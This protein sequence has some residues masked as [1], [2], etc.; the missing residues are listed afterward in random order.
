MTLLPLMRPVLLTRERV[1]FLR[2]QMLNM[3]SAD[4]QSATLLR[5]LDTLR[6]EWQRF[7][8]TVLCR[9]RTL[10][11]NMEPDLVGVIQNY[12]GVEVERL[13]T[14][15]N[16]YALY[17]IQGPPVRAGDGVVTIGISTDGF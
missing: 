16:G 17:G 13:Y 5:T 7:G 4:L 12:S 1:W 8:Q 15:V 3:N 11:Q 10:G 6:N 2:L 14:P 9:R